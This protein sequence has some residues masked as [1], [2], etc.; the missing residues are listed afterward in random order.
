MVC[1][2]FVDQLRRDGDQ[3]QELTF[4]SYISPPIS[5]RPRIILSPRVPTLANPHPYLRVVTV[6]L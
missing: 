4:R 1:E 5:D 2:W 3:E 6:A